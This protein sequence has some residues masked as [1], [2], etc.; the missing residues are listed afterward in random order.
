MATQSG[1]EKTCTQTLNQKLVIR[2]V[3][4]GVI[5][6]AVSL[7]QPYSLDRVDTGNAGLK[8]NLT[9]N[10]RGVSDYQYKN[11][12]VVCNNWA[13]QLYEFP[14]WQL[15][16]EYT[17][18]EVIAK[19]G[20]PLKINPTLNYSLKPDKI[21]DMFVNLRL[22]IEQLEQ[23]W[24]KTA[25]IGSIQDVSNKWKVEDIFN[26]RE[27]FEGQIILECNKR[28][29]KWFVI[30]QLR[31]NII[32]PDALV[33]SV[34]ANTKAIL[35]AQAE[36]KKVFV[37]QAQADKKIALARGDSANVVIRAMGNARASIESAKGEAESM[38]LKQERITPLYN[39]YIRANGWDGKYPEYWGVG[40]GSLLNLK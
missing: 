30:S 23:G 14:T 21:G 15:H 35:D 31:T 9:G 33:G 17:G 40:A 3:S 32:P 28:L 10:A 16:T 4:I 12:W 39:D 6:I 38:R 18:V 11:G 5:G 20:F 27:R 25:I 1:T 7:I 26:D 2:I 24:L 8:V 34:T 37:V 36:L 22:S 13:E 19:G 29:S